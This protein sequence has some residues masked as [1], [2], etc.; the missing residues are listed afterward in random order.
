MK[1]Q[2][3]IKTSRQAELISDP[4]CLS[5]INFIEEDAYTIKEIASNLEEDYTIIKKYMKD[6]SDNELFIKLDEDG[7]TK[8]KKSAKSYKMGSWDNN[9]DGHIYNHWVLG[10]IHHLES[11][12]TDLL[13]ILSKKDK[14]AFFEDLGYHDN[15][16][17]LSKVYLNPEEVQ[18]LQEI[19]NN[20]VQEHK[21]KPE[22]L[23]DKRPH[24]MA[25]ILNPDLTFIKNNTD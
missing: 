21:D 4:I 6:L 11:N 25:L 16:F 3:K 20:F 19:I 22:E 7:E 5:I 1:E 23:E 18:E 9:F 15:V 12:L 24:E 10:L 14:K 8:Y 2:M 13:K 17:N